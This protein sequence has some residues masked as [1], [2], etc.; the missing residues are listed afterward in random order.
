MRARCNSLRQ[1]AT[2]VADVRWLPKLHKPIGPESHKHVSRGSIQT[3]ERCVFEQRRE[4]GRIA[5]RL[6]VSHDTSMK[7]DAFIQCR[8]TP[9]MKAL[10]RRIAQ[11]EQITESA[12]VKQLLDVVLRSSVVEQLPPVEER[13]QRHARLSVRLEPGDR[14]LLRERATA[15][16]LPSATYASVV[17]RSHLR[18]VAPLLKQERVLLNQAIG[19][20][21]ATG[22]NLNQIARGINQGIHVAGPTLDDLRALLRAC[23]GLR[24]HV[25]RLLDANLRSWDIGHD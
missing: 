1:N 7:A 25:S 23:E 24:N 21:S 9:E 13:I 16:G 20:L 3:C 19:E 5:F 8:V 4:I 22:R 14:L 15:R 2:G 10:V 12:L 6:L 17:I 18:G 11:R